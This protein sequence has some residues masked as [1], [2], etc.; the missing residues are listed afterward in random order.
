MRRVPGDPGV[1]PCTRDS[2]EPEAG[3]RRAVG[4]R[5]RRTVEARPETVGP[6]ASGSRGSEPC[7]VPGRTGPRRSQFSCARCGALWPTGWPGTRTA[8]GPGQ[9]PAPRCPDCG[10]SGR[11]VRREPSRGREHSVIDLHWMLFRFAP[12]DPGPCPVCGTPRTLSHAGHPPPAVVR[13]LD[14]ACPSD[15][16]RASAREIGG[17]YWEA[18]EP[19]RW[20]SEAAHYA[21][22]AAVDLLRIAAGAGEVTEPPPWA[23]YESLDGGG[24]RWVRDDGGWRLAGEI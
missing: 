21:Y 23:E 17:H 10:C 4:E 14:W 5:P 15:G 19:A 18:L 16:A 1:G 9:A 24:E 20:E 3:R 2:G 13:P 7:A 6:G 8:P 11:P 22:W 12:L